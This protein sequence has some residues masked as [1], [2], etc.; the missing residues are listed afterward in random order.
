MGPVAQD[1]PGLGNR[2]G[3]LSQDK[4]IFGGQLGAQAADKAVKT[5]EMEE[6]L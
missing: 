3:S 1:A 6:E 2:F 5:E 4:I